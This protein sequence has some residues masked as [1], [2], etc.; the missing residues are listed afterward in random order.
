MMR[1]PRSAPSAWRAVGPAGPQAAST[2]STVRGRRARGTRASWSTGRLTV[3]L[4]RDRWWTRSVWVSGPGSARTHRA[5]ASETGTGARRMPD[6][7]DLVA[8]SASSVSL[9][10]QGSGPQPGVGCPRTAERTEMEA[11]A[12][13]APARDDVEL[14]RQLRHA[15]FFVQASLEQHGKLTG[16]LDV[17]LTSLIELLMD[18]GVID[19]EALAQAVDANREV[20]DAEARARFETDG[21]LPPW[22]TVMV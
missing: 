20:H 9:A 3:D 15:S 19:A 1:D 10:R 6:R 4:P 7:A 8:S 18:R 2:A 5:G 13:Q 21:I 11:P 16:K 22:P 14:E 12:A 17:Y